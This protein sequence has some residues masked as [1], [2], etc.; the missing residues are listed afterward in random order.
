MTEPS[1]NESRI[2]EKKK[3]R[4]FYLERNL[5]LRMEFAIWY[6]NYVTFGERERECEREKTHPWVD[7]KQ[8]LETAK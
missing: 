4:D 6:V 2:K 1:V 3:E 7:Y 8:T 5:V